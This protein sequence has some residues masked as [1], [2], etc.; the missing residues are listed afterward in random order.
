MNTKLNTNMFFT[1]EAQRRREGICPSNFFSFHKHLF[2]YSTLRHSYSTFSLMP[3]LSFKKVFS[4]SL[5]LCDS[6]VNNVLPCCS[7]EAL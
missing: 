6:A 5:R 1:A 4:F 7:M 2:I 3:F